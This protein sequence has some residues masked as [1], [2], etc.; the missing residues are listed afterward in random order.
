MLSNF[1]SRFEFFLL[2]EEVSR[3]GKFSILLKL[4]ST[5]SLNSKEFEL[6]AFHVGEIFL[7]NID[8][9]NVKQRQSLSLQFSSCHVLQRAFVFWKCLKG[10]TICFVLDNL[11]LNFLLKSFSLW[12]KVETVKFWINNFLKLK[13]LSKTS[14]ETKWKS[15]QFQIPCVPRTS[16]SF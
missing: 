11:I 15:L 8:E 6:K 2:F 9:Q 16:H 5:K 14:W 10:S 7:N 12:T 3:K 13:T 4:F 1:H